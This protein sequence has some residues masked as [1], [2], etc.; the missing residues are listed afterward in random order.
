MVYFSQIWQRIFSFA[1]LPFQL[2]KWLFKLPKGWKISFN[3]SVKYTVDNA[4]LPPS[5]FSVRGER[6]LKLMTDSHRVVYIRIKSWIQAESR[7]DFSKYIPG[8]QDRSYIPHC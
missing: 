4:G 7:Y 1:S 8:V 2:D 5:T 6:S 3:F